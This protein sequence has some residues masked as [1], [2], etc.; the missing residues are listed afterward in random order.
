M[1]TIPHACAW[2]AQ[3]NVHLTPVMVPCC[4]CNGKWTAKAEC[5]GLHGVPCR[6]S[7]DGGGGGVLVQAVPVGLRGITCTGRASGAHRVTCWNKL[8][9]E[10]PSLVPWFLDAHVLPTLRSGDGAGTLSPVDRMLV[11]VVPAGSHERDK[12]E[13]VR[14]RN[15]VCARTTS[16]TAWKYMHFTVKQAGRSTN[17]KK[18]VVIANSRVRPTNETNTATQGCRVGLVV[19]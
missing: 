13:I 1:H 18:W 11:T 6:H 19:I 17:K 15:A 3:S 8:W 12:D 14:G 16:L 7:A 4:S 2:H 9:G 5:G 10:G